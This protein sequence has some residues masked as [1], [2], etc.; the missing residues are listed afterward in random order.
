M[1]MVW[2]TGRVIRITWRIFGTFVETIRMVWITWTI[3]I[4]TCRIASSIGPHRQTAVYPRLQA[5]SRVDTGMVGGSAAAEPGGLALRHGDR[6]GDCCRVAGGGGVPVWSGAHPS[7][8][9][10]RFV[11]LM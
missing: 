11:M 9:H 8:H 5:L 6:P 2:M 1:M 4:T 7:N 3:W 10:L